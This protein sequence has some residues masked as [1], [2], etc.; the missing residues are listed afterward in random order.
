ML[1]FALL[2]QDPGALTDWFCKK[3]ELRWQDRDSL[4]EDCVT[5]MRWLEHGPLRVHVS[6]QHGV[7]EKVSLLAG[8]LNPHAT[9]HTHGV[10][11]SFGGRG[12][13]KKRGEGR[14]EVRWVALTTP[15]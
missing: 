6:V 10:S 1:H 3:H 7:L 4:S 12:G 9:V 5:C 11:S 14:G 13:E 8:G 15:R 2:L